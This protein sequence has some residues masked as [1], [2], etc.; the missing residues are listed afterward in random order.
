MSERYDRWHENE[1]LYNFYLKETDED[2]FRKAQI[3]AGQ[4]EYYTVYIPYTYAMAL[5]WH[6]YITTVFLGRSPVFQ[7]VARHGETKEQEQAVEALVD[8]Q[9]TNGNILPSLYLWPMDVAKYGLGILGVYWDEETIRV[10]KFIETPRT[11]FGI[12]IE[13][14]ETLDVTEELTQYIGNRVFNISP[15]N[16]RPDTRIPFHRIQESEFV[17]WTTELYWH[18]IYHNKE[19]YIN[20]STLEKISSSKNE[21]EQVW[22]NIEPSDAQNAPS[23]ESALSDLAPIEA[24]EMIVRLQPSAWGLGD[25]DR[26]ELWRFLVANKEVIIQAEPLDSYHG[27]FPIVIWEYD[28]DAYSLFKNSMIETLEPLNNTLNWLFNQHF[29]NVRSALNMNFIF[30]PSRVSYKDISRKSPG[31]A[32]RLLPAAYGSDVRT[33]I[34]QLQTNDVT[35][36]HFSDS[37]RVIEMMHRLVGLN[38]NIMGELQMGGR[39]T[40]TEVRASGTMALNRLKTN[41]EF[42]SATGFMSLGKMLLQNSQQYYDI[43]LKLRIAGDLAQGS[44]TIP[45][46]PQLISGFYD[47]VPVDGTMPVDRYAQ[48]NLMRELLMNAIQLPPEQIGQ[49]D[50]ARMLVHI[51]QLAGIKNINQF[52]LQTM[53]PGM[54]PQGMMGI[55]ELP[56]DPNMAERGL[57]APPEP[58]QMPGMGATG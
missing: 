43:E 5:T 41:A 36:A 11:L 16:F 4:Q 27:M 7:Y 58:G 21:R 26:T 15:F 34:T 50:W 3:E 9:L 18:K 53:P 12:P 40:A 42:G 32:I 8:Y 37:G 49:W 45:V 39:R 6:T 44:G 2:K 47:L 52:K 38:D 17:G 51:L 54:T 46:T 13:G 28:L 33:A 24:Y 30:D 10:R 22:F 19:D 20:L 48:A 55:N 56:M 35:Q 14:T 23:K 29:Y 31:K 25:S 57:G 1:K